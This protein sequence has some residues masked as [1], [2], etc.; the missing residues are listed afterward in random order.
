MPKMIV[1]IEGVVV[2]EVRLSKDRTTL[3]RRPYNDV[4]FDNLAV[5][6]EHAVVS[7]SD[8]EYAIE[9]LNST[10]GTYVN[11]RAV[12]KHVLR[13]G[14]AIGIG[15]YRVK[16][17]QDNREDDHERVTVV[18]DGAALF[19]NEPKEHGRLLVLNGNAAGKA[20]TLTKPSTTIGKPSQAVMAIS[21]QSHGHSVSLVEGVSAVTLNGEPIT[22]HGSPL[23]SGDLIEIGGVQMQFHRL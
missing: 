16:F 6:G 15:K 20:V 3:G 5:S 21:R 7:V 23:Q 18:D 8:G 2:R 11:G 13:H 1:S 10:N 9:D 19:G 22:T 4:V 17:Y 12:T 14:D